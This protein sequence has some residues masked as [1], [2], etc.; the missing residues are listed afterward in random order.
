MSKPPPTPA[1]HAGTP[2]TPATRPARDLPD[3]IRTFLERP[4][5]ATIATT[6]PDGRPHQAVAWY[7]LE[8]DGTILVNSRAP[9]HWPDNIGRTGQANLAVIDPDDDLRWVGLACELVEVVDDVEQA[10]DDIVALAH[11]YRNDNPSS[12]SIAEF[13]TQQ[14]ISF[15]L[16]PVRIH[17]HLED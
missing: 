14:R 8:P 5:V 17:D 16:R 15:R 9:R 12:K 6:S 11:R 7:R 1:T 3:R 2:A 4:I 13:R 10:R